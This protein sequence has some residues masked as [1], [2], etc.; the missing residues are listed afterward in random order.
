MVYF[1]APVPLSV[2]PTIQ[3]TVSTPARGQ[4]QGEQLLAGLEADVR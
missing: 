4:D 1:A 3:R 2:S